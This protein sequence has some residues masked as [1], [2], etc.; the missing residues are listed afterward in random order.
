MKYPAAMPAI[1]L[2]GTLALAGPGSAGAVGA[3]NLI[4]EAYV[5]AGIMPWSYQG[6][7]EDVDVIGGRLVGGVMFNDYLG[8]EAHFGWLGEDDS[9]ND[10][11]VELD[12]VD[13]VL[14]RLNRPLNAAVDVYALAGF[15]SVR[16]VLR[17]FTIAGTDEAP[18]A[19]G[20]SFGAGGEFRLNAHFSV[21]V[22]AVSYLSEPDFD[23]TA[24]GAS[25]RYHF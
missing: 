11:R 23:F 5:G 3:A 1:V 4:D 24:L 16:M 19:S 21:A 6:S 15:S 22:D 10:R 20:V 8:V 2:A 18:S 17:P 7:G 9:G 25:L 14:L 13:S 12:S